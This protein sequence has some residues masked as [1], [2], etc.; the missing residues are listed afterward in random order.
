MG[1]YSVSFQDSHS[2]LLLH[3]PSHPLSS[4]PPPRL[5][6]LTCPE[7]FGQVQGGGAT[8][9]L[10]EGGGEGAKKGHRGVAGAAAAVDS[11]KQKRQRVT[12]RNGKQEN[13]CMTLAGCGRGGARTG[14]S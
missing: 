9:A 4:P 8:S 5:P 13:T 2:I 7:T 11:E 3:F 14:W 6:P 1:L 10:G 12:D